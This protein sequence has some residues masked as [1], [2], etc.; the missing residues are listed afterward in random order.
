HEVVHSTLFQGSHPRLEA[1]MGY[2]Y[3]L[4]SGISKSQFT[5]WHLDHHNEL[6]S[7]EGGDPKRH[8][9]TP[10]IV[11]RWYKLLYCTP[12]LFPIY[13]RAAARETATYPEAL[14]RRIQR[15][16][17]LTILAHV[18]AMVLLGWLGGFGVFVK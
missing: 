16:R 9:L 5:R 8:W 7:P 10:K 6:G 2:L 4:P 18:S 14:R 12:A 1:F 11:R 17:K 15:E 13:F 3:A